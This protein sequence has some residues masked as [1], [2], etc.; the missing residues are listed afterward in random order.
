[1]NLPPDIGG[2]DGV[3]IPVS[4]AEKEILPPDTEFAGMAY[5]DPRV[6]ERDWL[7]RIVCKI[8]LSG[9]GKAQHPSSGTVPNR[10]GLVGVEQQD[11]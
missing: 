7:D 11:H 1:M 6:P 2:L 10:S 3:A 9:A 8:V 4:Q 5:G